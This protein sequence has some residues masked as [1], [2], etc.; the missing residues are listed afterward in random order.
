MKII[1]ASKTPLV[2]RESIKSL[3]EY[4]SDGVNLCFKEHNKL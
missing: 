4:T 3:N 2:K 1:K